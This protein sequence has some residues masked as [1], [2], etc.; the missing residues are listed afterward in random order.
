MMVVVTIIMRMRVGNPVVRMLMRMRCAGRRRVGM[1]MIVVPVVVRVLMSVCDR[2]L[3]V[4]VRMLGH[5]YLLW[6][7]R[8]EEV[9]DACIR[10]RPPQSRKQSQTSQ[11][12]SNNL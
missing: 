6:C 8:A 7:S 1:G 4:R 12:Y 11:M 9:Q 3:G 10:S 5:G 2:I